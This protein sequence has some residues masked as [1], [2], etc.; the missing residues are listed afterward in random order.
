[1]HFGWPPAVARAALGELVDSDELVL[2][3]GAYRPAQST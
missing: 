3:P 2:E 1:L